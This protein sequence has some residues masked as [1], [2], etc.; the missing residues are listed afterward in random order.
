MSLKRVGGRGDG[1]I[2]LL[3]WWWVPGGEALEGD[4]GSFEGEFGKERRRIR[5]IAQ[6]KA[7]K[8]KLGPGYVRELE[9]V[10]YRLAAS[11]SLSSQLLPGPSSDLLTNFSSSAEDVVAVLISQSAFTKSTVLH[12]HSSPIPFLLIHLPPLTPHPTSSHLLRDARASEDPAGSILGSEPLTAIWNP[13]L[14]GTKG[15]LRGE[16]EMRWERTVDPLGVA[17]DRPGLWWRGRK[18]GRMIPDGYES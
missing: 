10:V 9:G 13:A 1:G 12:A 6:C 5:V 18:V 7:E 16:M 4:G 11:S 17:S 15:V 2:D 14:G 8:K 3:G